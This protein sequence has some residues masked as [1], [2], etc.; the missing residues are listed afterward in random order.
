VPTASF[1]WVGSEGPWSAG[2][3]PS[4]WKRFSSRTSERT[5]VDQILAWLDVP[6]AA[7]RPRL[8]TA[9]FHGADHE[10]H[11]GGP[12]S[13]GV[14]KTLR[15]QDRQ[16]A[17]LVEGLEVRGRFASTTL[18]FVSDHGMATARRRVDLGRALREAGI[19][20]RTLGIGGFSSVYLS[21]DQPT[22]EELDQT[23]AVAREEGL[24]AYARRR[25][26]NDWHVEDVRFGDV[27]VRAPLGTA[28]VTPTTLIE[29]FHGYDPALP[30]M[31][32]LLVARGRGIRAGG[33]VGRVSNLSVAPTVLALLGLPVPP[34][35]A[36]PPL[37]AMLIGVA[38][39]A[40]EPMTSRSS[41]E[42]DARRGHVGEG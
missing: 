36:A 18:I 34:Q 21:T 23:V 12:D 20:S 5:K 9:W 4:S 3:G 29:G 28:I 42:R 33:E 24:E 35:M 16:I 14:S 11:V 1:Y 17:R 37:E 8:V 30:E 7:R 6:D 22:R 10:G 2:P 31:A 25:A 39:R 38:A 26:P 27:V 19:R 13:P 41:T 32:G 40:A 15:L